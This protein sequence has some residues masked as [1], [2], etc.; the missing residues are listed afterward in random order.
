MTQ[1]NSHDDLQADLE[2]L[3]KTFE[4]EEREDRR[5]EAQRRRLGLPEPARDI[6]A[7]KGFAD[8]GATPRL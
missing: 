4:A 3:G 2:A 1:H 6:R 8:G 7:F 5:I